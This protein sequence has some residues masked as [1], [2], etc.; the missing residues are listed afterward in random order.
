VIAL[1]CWAKERCVRYIE[2]FELFVL[3]KS[4]LIPVNH[5]ESIIHLDHSPPLVVIIFRSGIFPS[6][7]PRLSHRDTVESGRYAAECGLCLLQAKA[8][9]IVFRVA[10]SG[11]N[12]L[13]TSTKPTTSRVRQ[14]T[15]ILT[16]AN[17]FSRI[18]SE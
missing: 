18:D 7:V 4:Y 15:P 1:L 8:A 3:C 6:V 2:E 16:G 17:P 12:I 13:K 11:P 9:T 10:G 5:Q 14:S